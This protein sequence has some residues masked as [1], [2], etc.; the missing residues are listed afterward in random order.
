MK[1]VLQVSQGMKNVYGK[2][3]NTLTQQDWLLRFKENLPF[4]E[5]EMLILNLPQTA[6]S[7]KVEAGEHLT[8]EEEATRKEES[9]S[10]IYVFA[11]YVPPGKH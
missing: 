10:D 6:V 3:I 11:G 1:A 4:A 2:Q 5:S 8:T 9:Q 7:K